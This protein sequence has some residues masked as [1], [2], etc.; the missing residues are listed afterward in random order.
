MK[1]S[2]F[3]LGDFVE[4]LRETQQTFDVCL[5]SG[6][7]YHMK[8]PAELL[9][10][11]AKVCD[12][13]I[14][15]THYYDRKYLEAKPGFKRQFSG[16]ELATHDGFQHTLYKQ[17]YR[18]ALKWTG[19]CGGSDKYSYWMNYDDILRCLRHFGFSRIE[20]SHHEP[21]HPHGPAFCLFCAK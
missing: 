10:L 15:W 19:F 13:A 4:F 6:V 17:H 1:R 9:G 5:A 16:Q 11:I 12:E 21:D 20:I 2:S 14:I 8:N 18:A 3:I 7:L